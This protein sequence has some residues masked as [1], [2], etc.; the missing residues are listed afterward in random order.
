[1][2][3]VARLNTSRLL[4]KRDAFRGAVVSAALRG[5]F[6]VTPSLFVTFLE[7]PCVWK[8]PSLKSAP[9][10]FFLPLHTQLSLFFL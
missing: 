10:L 7:Y 6:T 4:A 3:L 9:S 2:L 1:M 8:E 5:A